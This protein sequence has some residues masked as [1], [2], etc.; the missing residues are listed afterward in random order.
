[1]INKQLLI[2]KVKKAI[3]VYPSIIELKREIKE[4]DGM[5][6]YNVT[7]VDDVATFNAF[8]NNEGSSLSISFSDGGKVEK[9]SKSTLLVAYSEE[10]KLLKDDSFTLD[11]IDYRVKNPNLQFDVCYLAELEVI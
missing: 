3:E 8:L 5:G 9:V 4:D 2:R 11:G 7:G 1:M 6:G 10:F